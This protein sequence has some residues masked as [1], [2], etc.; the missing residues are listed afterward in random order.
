[1][2][3][4]RYLDRKTTLSDSVVVSLLDTS[5]TPTTPNEPPPVLPPVEPPTGVSKATSGADVFTWTPSNMPLQLNGLGGTDTLMI[6][7]LLKDFAMSA[8]SSSTSVT[9]TQTA[10]R[11]SANLQNIERLSFK[12]LNLALDTQASSSPGKAALLAG[13][14]F[15]PDFVR[16]PQVLGALISMFDAPNTTDGQVADFALN[17]MLGDS[18]SYQAVVNMLYK[19][20]AGVLPNS[21]QATSYIHLLEV[22]VYTPASLALFAANHELNKINIGFVGIVENGISYLPLG[23]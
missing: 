3:Y 17:V 11:F 18:P 2:F 16:D 21:T 14:V 1:M 20:L 19:N 9:I 12:D 5:L 8:N 15:G 4:I 6:N 7:G 23:I 22:G 13:A 10:T